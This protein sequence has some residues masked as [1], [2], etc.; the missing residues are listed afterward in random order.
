M[1]TR[2]EL[3]KGIPASLFDIY[4]MRSYVPKGHEA[5]ELLRP[6][7]AN[8]DDVVR[9]LNVAFV[10]ELIC[11]MRYMR[12]Y[13]TAAG[14]ESGRIKTSFLIHAGEEMMHAD[15]L[16]KRI[17]ELGGKPNFS[18]D[19]LNITR[20]VE[21][22]TGDSLGNMIKKVIVDEQIAMVSYQCMIV[23][24]ADCDP[25]TAAILEEILVCE[26]THARNFSLLLQELSSSAPLPNI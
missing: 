5:G 11:L 8:G 2:Y 25:A 9:M 7:A 18:F 23:Y 19:G 14:R 6:H 26:E 16:A 13:F 15:R 3:L 17:V 12:H 20:H 10:D 4:A 21:S 1:L 22:S 24:L